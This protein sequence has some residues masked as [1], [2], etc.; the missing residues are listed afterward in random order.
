MSTPILADSAATVP[1]SAQ[2]NKSANTT[3]PLSPTAKT[4]STAKVAKNLLPRAEEVGR[5][6]Y[7]LLSAHI[8]KHS[9]TFLRGGDGSLHLVIEGKR[10]RLS[11]QS[12]VIGVAGLLF[13]TC[14]ISSLTPGAQAGIQRLVVEGYRQAERMRLRN[15]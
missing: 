5:A 10:I 2:P 3:A 1:Q 6:V 4:N 13:D 12:D 11:P 15:F 8:T 7:K 14:N 9:A